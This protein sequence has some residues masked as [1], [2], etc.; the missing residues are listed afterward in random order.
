MPIPVTMPALSPTMTEG[1]LATWRKREGDAVKAGDVIAEIE[2]DKATM[3]LEAVD[4]G[5]LGRIVVPAGA[6]GVKVNSVIAMLLEEGEDKSALD[7]NV[8]VK[9]APAAMNPLPQAGEG[10]VRVSAPVTALGSNGRILASPLAR[11]LAK[12]Q[13]VDLGAVEGSGPG[14]RIVQRDLSGAPKAVAAAQAKAPALPAGQ[15]T[16]KPHSNI[17][18][19]TAERLAEAWRTIPHIYLSVDCVVDKLL[20]A[21]AELNGKVPPEAGASSNVYKLS[22]NDFVIRA[23]AFALRKVPEMNAQC[24]AAGTLRL[25]SIDVAVAVALPNGLI[26]PILRRV[27]QKGLADIS[28]EM[29]ALAEKAR[30]GKLMPEEYQGG[31]FTVSNLGMYGVKDFGAIV[32]PPQAGILAVGAA[33]KRPV[34]RH[35]ALAIGTVM[36][37]TLSCDHRVVDGA[38]GAQ[39]LTAVKGFLEEP[40][41]MLL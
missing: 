3:E 39:F 36:T 16:L 9:P 21:R 8:E 17:R 37:C 24:T 32:N 23:V 13:G 1:R 30:A 2:T 6:A 10:R 33:E 26:T 4:A 11:K 28:K 41:T 40:M 38:I 19:I 29:K 15:G 12:E 22:V 5:T 18:R 14:G 31:G 35:G 7:K 27:D 20:D 34:V 25:S